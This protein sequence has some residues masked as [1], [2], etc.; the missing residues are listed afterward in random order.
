MVNVGKYSIHVTRICTDFPFPDF[1]FGKAYDQ[2]SSKKVEG[3]GVESSVADP[4]RASRNNN[5]W[6][7]MMVYLP[8]MNGGF[9]Y[10]K[11]CM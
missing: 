7:F 8:T 2:S 3:T 1:R 10:S 6:V 4:S 11:Y 5:P 9:L